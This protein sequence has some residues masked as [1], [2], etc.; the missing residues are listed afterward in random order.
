MQTKTFIATFFLMTLF[1]PSASLFAGG[2]EI[3]LQDLGKKTAYPKPPTPFD[4]D[5]VRNYKGWTQEKEDHL[6][7]VLAYWGLLFH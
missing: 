1:L 2:S 3:E 4:Q 7:R 6:N 5:R